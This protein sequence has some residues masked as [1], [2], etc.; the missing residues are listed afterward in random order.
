MPAIE[1]PKTI[2]EGTL[3]PVYPPDP[4][5]TGKYYEHVYDLYVMEGVSIE[6]ARS[7]VYAAMNEALRKLDLTLYDMGGK[8]TRGMFC[9]IFYNI[10]PTIRKHSDL[11]AQ[12]SS[13]LN[14]ASGYSITGTDALF[15]SEW[16]AKKFAWWLLG[17]GTAIASI[18]IGT[19][20]KKKK[21]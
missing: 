5:E 20:A 10:G 16:V 17:I 4:V 21:R 14:T 2:P 11:D 15:M 8:G 9:V 19:A 13:E 12:F 7:W 6:E 3:V 1:F 18:A